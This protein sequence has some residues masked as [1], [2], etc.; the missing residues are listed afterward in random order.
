MA[1]LGVL[2]TSSC[3]QKGEERPP[4]SQGGSVSTGF[5]PD[6]GLGTGD[7][8]GEGG[9]TG[10]AGSETMATGLVQTFQ[11]SDFILTAP[12]TEV[13]QIWVMD[14][15][16]SDYTQ[17]N[18]DGATFTTPLTGQSQ[19]MA[20]A[21]DFDTTHMRTISLW[22]GLETEPQLNIVPRAALSDVLSG[23]IGSTTVIDSRAFALIQVFDTDGETPKAG[24][25]PTIGAA[26]GIAFYDQ[27]VWSDAADSTA[28]SGLFLAYNVFTVPLVG[29]DTQVILSG[30][31]DGQFSVRLAEG[32]ITIVTYVSK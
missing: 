32:A 8:D 14:H 17:A 6:G 2:A 1:V 25:V 23:L 30:T 29:Q 18:Y 5:V 3:S 4:L 12:Y 26:E 24:V 21:P 19:W 15:G 28:R 27:G 20:V 10:D 9:A 11:D 22:D 13:A 16:S 31:V 7:G